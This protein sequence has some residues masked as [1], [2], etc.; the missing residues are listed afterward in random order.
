MPIDD[1]RPVNQK[2]DVLDASMDDVD[3]GATVPATRVRITHLTSNIH[4]DDGLYIGASKL[5]S[6]CSA[7]FDMERA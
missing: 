3:R 5:E 6:L 7:C 1:G 2:A 4:V